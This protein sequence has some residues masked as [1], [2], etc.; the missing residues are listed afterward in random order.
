[1]KSF[2]VSEEVYKKI[3]AYWTAYSK[4][5]EGINT[6]LEREFGFRLVFGLDSRYPYHAI[7]AEKEEYITAFLLKI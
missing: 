6:Y 1:M 2:N 3:I 4:E 7:I 5:S